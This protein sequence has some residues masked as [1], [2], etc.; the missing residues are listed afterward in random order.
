M[1]KIDP[2]EVHPSVPPTA[3]SNETN[4]GAFGMERAITEIKRLQLEVLALRNIIR[5]RLDSSR[6]D[7]EEKLNQRVRTEMEKLSR[8]EN[9]S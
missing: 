7:F 6:S 1:K 8:N 4:F 5:D 9:Q 2:F 3:S